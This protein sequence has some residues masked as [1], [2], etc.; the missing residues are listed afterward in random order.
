MRSILAVLPPFER[1]VPELGAS[2]CD[3]VERGVPEH[4]AL[5]PD[6][7]GLAATEHDALALDALGR[8]HALLARYSPLVL[9][10]SGGLDSRFL[11][12]TAAL[13]SHEGVALHLFH[14]AGPHVPEE[15]TLAARQWAEARGLPLLL[16]PVNPLA[17]ERVRSNSPQRCYHCKTELFSRLREA[18]NNHPELGAYTICDGTNADDCSMYRPGLRAL[19]ELGIRSPLA[20]AGIGKPLIRSLGRTLGLDNPEQTARPCLLTRFAYDVPAS[21]AAVQALAVAEASIAALLARWAGAEG[22]GRVLPDFRLRLTGLGAA[23]TGTGKVANA[24]ER[25]EIIAASGVGD[26]AGLFLPGDYDTELHLNTGLEPLWL[27]KLA[28]AVIQAD[29]RAPRIRIMA[30]LQGF[31]DKTRL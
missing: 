8:L 17:L 5:E 28:A 22:K 25:M 31:Y 1:K 16:L 24:A 23:A 3:A 12:H 9:A 6:A 18:V 21:P 11:A 14:I 2:E 26:S 10:F 27:E 29:F 19:E 15:E 13:W 20:E 7:P 4:N 30:D